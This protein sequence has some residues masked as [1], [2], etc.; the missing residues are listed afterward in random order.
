VTT[1]AEPPAT[2]ASGAGVAVTGRRKQ[3]WRAR[4]R[5][6]V[7][8]ALLACLA[9]ALATL[10]LLHVRVAY[11]A[12]VGLAFAGL[13]VVHLAQR[14]HRLG[15]MF[16]GLVG[17]RPRVARE[18]RLLASDAILAFLAANVVV[19][20]VIDWGR[21]SPVEVNFPPPLE[22]ARIGARPRRCQAFL[23][24]SA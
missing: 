19:S 10:Q 13:V 9:G 20:G 21:G 4:T 23:P 22:A 17:V 15:R 24:E 8:L 11:H 6:L 14:R 5:F 3:V 2:P 16:Q 12:D 18:V 7:H 1:D